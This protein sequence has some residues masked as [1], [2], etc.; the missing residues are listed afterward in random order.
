[1]DGDYDYD[2]KTSEFNEAKFQIFR[3]HNSWVECKSRRQNGDLVGLRYAL[4]SVA[5]ELNNDAIRVDKTKKEDE[6]KFVHRIKEIDKKIAEE[7][8]KKEKKSLTILYELLKEKERI[9]R[10]LQEE[11]G[12]GTRLKSTE[13]RM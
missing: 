3:L 12:K 6:D 7:I 8:E 1:M 2:V 11:A 10:Q 13:Y 4:D 5:L 9:L